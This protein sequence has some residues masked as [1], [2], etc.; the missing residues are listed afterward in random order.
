MFSV[1]LA[2]RR[3]TLNLAVKVIITTGMM[4]VMDNPKKFH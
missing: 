3:I 1:L 2:C 4:L